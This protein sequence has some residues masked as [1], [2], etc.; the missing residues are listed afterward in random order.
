M[1]LIYYLFSLCLL[2]S[3]TP[4]HA[5]DQ[6]T[7]RQD[8]ITPNDFLGSDTERIQAAVDSAVKT[9]KKVVIP[10]FNANGGNSWKIDKAILLPS[11]II[12]ILENCVIQ[13]SD[14]CRDNMFRSDNIIIGE[15]SI[16]WNANI[17]I[18][19]IG[20]VVLRGADNPRATGDAARTLVLT[21]Q[22]GRV[23]YGSDAGRPDRKQK[24]DWRNIMILMAYV[25]G[26][27]LQN[28]T[29]ENSHAWAVSFERTLNA[30]ISDIK[31]HLPE[32]QWINGKR[33]VVHNRDGI[34]LRQGCKYFRIN[35]IS[36]TTEDDFIALTSLG[37]V[38]PSHAIGD[39]NST[40]VTGSGWYGP[41]DDIE[42][43]SITNIQCETNTRA[44]AIR[45][46]DSAGIHHIYINGVMAKARYN[47][48]LVGGRGYG[49]PS[50]PGRIHD[51]HAMNLMGTGEAL[52]LIESPIANCTFLN[53][54][55]AGPK[56]EP[57]VYSIDR[58]EIKNLVLQN[59]I[60]N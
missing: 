58:S 49:K 6:L 29:I 53:G 2:L 56:V 55:Y 7:R 5:Q 54:V 23:S 39:F 22:P 41:Q 14:S 43:I 30:D 34:D 46:V 33:V 28:V 4:A 15:R 32:E 44:I 9:T 36:G 38:D 45:A 52:I 20:E 31:F 42:Q 47:N 57:V 50:L 26:F 18:I 8:D 17:R 3:L 1:K 27:T 25:K 12:V 11:D 59:L 19:G 40:M 48:M 21:P 24:G 37:E 35:N 10:A 51:I 60:K 16:S 13:L